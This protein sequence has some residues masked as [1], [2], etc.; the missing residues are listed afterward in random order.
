MRFVID[1]D[2]VQPTFNNDPPPV[3]N[4]LSYRHNVSNLHVE[5]GKILTE[6]DVTSGF[7]VWIYLEVCFFLFPLTF[8]YCWPNVFYYVF[9]IVIDAETRRKMCWNSGPSKNHC[10]C[11][12][13]PLQAWRTVE[14]FCWGSQSLLRCS[15]ENWCTGGWKQ[16]EYLC[17]SG[18]Q[19][20]CILGVNS[21]LYLVMNFQ[22][23]WF[24]F[25]SHFPLSFVKYFHFDNF[26]LV[27][28]CLVLH[29]LTF[30]MTSCN[31]ASV[32]FMTNL[33]NS[34]ICVAFQAIFN[35]KY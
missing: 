13:W 14:A 1:K 3:A 10:Q 29:N 20:G 7:L 4:S 22:L 33:Q 35:G 24:L 19:L 32:L 15:L 6:Y 9:V 27:L 16:W 5:F 2:G 30:G 17:F 34:F 25:C 18:S 23:S 21:E 11:W 31:G 12:G 28:N 26:S 8:G